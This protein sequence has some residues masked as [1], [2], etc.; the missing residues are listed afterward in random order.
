MLRPP[1]TALK[2]IHPSGGLPTPHSALTKK[3]TTSQ[4]LIR[5]S[6]E[7][8]SKIRLLDLVG[9]LRRFGQELIFLLG[10]WV[11]SM[12]SLES[13]QKPFRSLEFPPSCHWIPLLFMLGFQTASLHLSAKDLCH[14]CVTMTTADHKKI[15]NL[16][17]R[18]QCYTKW[19]C[20]VTSCC[21]RAEERSGA[22]S[23]LPGGFFLFVN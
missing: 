10:T 2:F 11:I 8:W 3:N 13:A 5:N 22:S 23:R 19:R 4:K 12:I 21:Q 1:D 6:V 18:C 14:G 9:I 16:R 7:V 20:E 15:M 17:S